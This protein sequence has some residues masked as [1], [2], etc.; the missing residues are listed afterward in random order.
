MLGHH[1]EGDRTAA[2]TLLTETT[3]SRDD[4]GFA[5][6]PTACAAGNRDAAPARS[7][8]PGTGHHPRR[9]ARTGPDGRTTALA[10]T[11]PSRSLRVFVRIL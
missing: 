11:P 8:T 1:R 5:D 7:T 2:R 9:P 4:A 6:R 10:R 3:G